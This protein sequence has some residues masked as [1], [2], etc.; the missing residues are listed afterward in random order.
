MTVLY[1]CRWDCPKCGQSIKK[2]TELYEIYKGLVKCKE[3]KVK[4]DLI[5]I[6]RIVP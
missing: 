6:R 3:C 5:D 4:M 1:N 2:E